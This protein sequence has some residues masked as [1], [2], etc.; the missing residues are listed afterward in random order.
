MTTLKLRSGDQELDVKGIS[1]NGVIASGFARVEVLLTFFIDQRLFKS[2]E[3]ELEFPLPENA[4]VSGYSMETENGRMVPASVVEKEKARVTFEQ[5][6]RAGETTSL[7]EVVKGNSFKVRE[8]FFFN[9]FQIYEF[10][11]YFYFLI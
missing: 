1:V 11:F 3:G 7:V 6:M 8:K 5:E 4:T 2:V 10:G 9:F